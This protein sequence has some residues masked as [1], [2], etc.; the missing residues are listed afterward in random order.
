MSIAALY[1]SH[2]ATLCI[3]N[4][5]GEVGNYEFERW[6]GERYWRFPPQHDWAVVEAFDTALALSG[7]TEPERVYYQM[8]PAVWLDILRQMW[9]NTE[10]IWE[11]HH[12]S[13][14]AGARSH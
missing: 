12:P 4:D 1:G 13:H 5:A 3:L 14:A 10:F 6:F 8:V 9:P 7:V 11:A 2:D